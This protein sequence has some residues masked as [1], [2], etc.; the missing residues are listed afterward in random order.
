MNKPFKIE[1]LFLV[2]NNPQLDKENFVFS[3][4]AEYPYFTRTENN[5][6]ILGYVEYLDDEHIIQGNSLAVGMISMKFH[7]MSHDFYAGQFTKTLIP[8]FESFDE[9]LALYFI[10]ILNK[11][12][13]YYQSYLVREFVSRVSNTICELPVIESPNPNH[14][15]T[16]DDIDWQ[17]MR[18]CVRKFEE[19]C[20][21]ELEEER[22]REFDT[23]LKATG[24]NNC[25]L[26]DNEKK[27]IKSAYKNNDIQWGVFRVG[28]L[29]Y[30]VQS[31]KVKSFNKKT[32]TKTA[33]DAEFS[34]PL[35][36]AKMGD[37]GIMFYARPSDVSSES[38]TID[39]VQNGA[40]ATGKVYAQPQRTGVLWDAYL[41]KLISEPE[42]MSPQILFFLATSIEKTIREKFTYDKKATWERVKEA[43]ITL[44]VMSGVPNWGYMEK[45]IRATEK[46]VI[47]DVVKRKDKQIE[48]MKKVVNQEVS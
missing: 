8:I 6:G 23:Y 1:Q 13:S 45:Y 48:L 47:V 25:E 31:E 24:L 11:H 43:K 7:Y 16:V 18:K 33:P 12:S 37:N 27:L 39:I 46:L 36:N 22:V 9:T 44:P 2:I 42:N 3:E 30:K 35:V 10:G 38:M 19:E 41:V 32:D 34:L 26:T 15:Y 5:N 14:K 4:K 17:Y 21:R 40:V 28:D 20:V 29:F